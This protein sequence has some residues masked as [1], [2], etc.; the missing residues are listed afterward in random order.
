MNLKTLIVA[1]AGL[2]ALVM[3]A[4]A[5]SFDLGGAAKGTPSVVS[6]KFAGQPAVAVFVRGPADLMYAQVGS[7]NGAT[8]TASP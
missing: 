1:V 5:E 3:P 7:S 2:A 4:A 6:Y 8:W